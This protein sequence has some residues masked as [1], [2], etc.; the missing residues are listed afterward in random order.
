MVDGPGA[1]SWGLPLGL[2]AKE[3]EIKAKSRE[4]VRYYGKY[5]N[6]ER[7]IQGLV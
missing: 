2:L 7:N 6:V 4:K 1:D 3:W 5:F